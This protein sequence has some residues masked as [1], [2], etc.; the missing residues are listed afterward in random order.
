M[1]LGSLTELQN[2]L[3]VAKDVGYMN[4]DEF[5]ALANQNVIVHKL[6]IGLLKSSRAKI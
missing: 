4:K 5:T 3:L 6:I 2:Q 1:A